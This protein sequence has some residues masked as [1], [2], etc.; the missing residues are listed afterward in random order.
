MKKIKK[1]SQKNKLSKKKPVKKVSTKK[2]SQKNKLSKKKPV[3]KVSTKK[4]SQ[5]NKLYKR[6]S[7]KKVLVK[8]KPAKKIIKQKK[9]NLISKIIKLQ[10][11]LK[12]E[13]KIKINFSLEKYIQ[14]FFDK[15]ANTIQDYKTLKAEDKRRRK[16]E[17]IEKKENERIFLEKQKIEKEQAQ[18]KFKEKAL[19]EE[20]KLEKRKSKRYKIIFT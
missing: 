17:K 9:E 3:K 2:K 14:V 1:K 12:P 18:T 15:I 5:K 10:H 20:I 19:K 11:S 6:E 7:V 4:K 16:L 8:K 13:F